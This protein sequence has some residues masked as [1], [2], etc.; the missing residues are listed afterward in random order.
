M[1]VSV[2]FPQIA[3]QM[4]WYTAE[5]GRQPWIVYG[6]LRTS[7]G[8]SKVVSAGQVLASIIMF[9]IIYIILFAMFIFLLDRKI[10]HGPEEI[11]EEDE[12]QVREKFVEAI[13][14]SSHPTTS[15][16]S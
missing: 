12:G 10:K 4:G 14:S 8:L 9:A 2:G 6:L 13:S 15:T 3:N 5:M 11:G 7:D 16:E 1:I